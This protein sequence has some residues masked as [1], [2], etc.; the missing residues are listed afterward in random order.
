MSEV[1]ERHGG[2]RVAAMA[3]VLRCARA[4]VSL[5]SGMDWLG[6]NDV[7]SGMRVVVSFRLP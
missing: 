7:D 3:R 6:R 4:G 1:D 5:G 2:G